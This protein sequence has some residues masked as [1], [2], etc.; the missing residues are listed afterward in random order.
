MGGNRNLNSAAKAKKDEFYT[1]LT[2]IERELWHYRPAF[3]GKIVLCNCDDPYE[4]EFFKYF[5]M[6]FNSLGLK[7]L[8]ATCYDGSPIAQT[9]LSLFDD[10]SERRAFKLELTEVR[11]WN[12]DGAIDLK[13]VEYFLLHNEIPTLEGNGDFRSPECV[14]L[15]KE[16][17]IVVTN[18]P[19]SLF[20]EYVAQLMAYEKQFLILGNKNAITYKEIFPLLMQNKMWL[21]VT[22][23]SNEIYF[24]V[25][26]SFIEEAVARNK[27]RTVVMRNDKYMA[28]SQACWFTN[29]DVAK[30]HED[31]PLRRKYSPEEYPRY[32][33]YD[34]IEVSRT[35]DIP[36]DYD[37]VMG[38]P[39]SFMDKYNPEQFEI[40][41]CSYVYGD[42]GCHISGT[43]WG[44][45]IGGRDIYKR[46]FIRRRR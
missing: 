13:D 11:D 8:I 44:T 17:D 23:M 16:A 1:Q 21:G 46:L 3:R 38:V 40:L 22:P 4:S 27:H 28:R 34:A 31:I 5:A 9:E 35:A 45:K 2:D 33:N 24:D 14:E 18:P 43:S 12:G 39:I 29:I 42:P 26:Q 15:L 30:R 25:P 7:K 37:G 32:D 19:F 6:Q 10:L 36:I 20:R 41:G